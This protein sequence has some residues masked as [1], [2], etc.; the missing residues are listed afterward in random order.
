[1]QSRG[2][3]EH[4]QACAAAKAGTPKQ[5][6]LAFL[7]RNYKDIPRGSLL[8]ASNGER[9]DPGTAGAPSSADQVLAPVETIY[10][11]ANG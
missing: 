3:Y 1:M 11:T 9:M 8:E 10:R 4:A 7:D 6:V 2:I 5:R